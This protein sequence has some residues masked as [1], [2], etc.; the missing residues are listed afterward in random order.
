MKTDKYDLII[1][2]GGMVGA[3]LACMLV[4]YGFR[5][6]LVEAAVY[7]STNQPSFD[8]RALALTYSSGVIFQNLNVWQGLNTNEATAIRQIEVSDAAAGGYVRLAAKDVGQEALGWNVEARAIGAQ[9][10]RVLE[11]N[12]CVSI[13]S[14]MILRQVEINDACVSAI[15]DDSEEGNGHPLSAKLLIIADGSNSALREQLKFI[16]R[17]IPYRQRALVCRVE[18]DRKNRGCAYEH[19]TRSGPL[20]LLPFCENGYS[21]VWTQE[22]EDLKEVLKLSRSEFLVKLQSVFGP[23]AGQFKQLIGERK[24]YPLTLS[25]LKNFA[26]PRVAVV[27]NASHTVHPVAGQGFNLGL[28]DV[29][30]LAQVLRDSHN[31]GWDIGNIE[32]L[33]KFERWRSQEGE[34]VTWFTDGLIQVF[35]N[36]IPVLTPARNFGLDLLQLLPP[37]KRWLLERTM[38]MHGRQPDLA[39]NERK[40]SGRFR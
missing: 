2:G 15:A 40:D 18:T 31:R 9:L 28:R 4:G 26:K 38:G 13:L 36:E 14:P 17:S 16:P 37:V 19:F 35:A 7:S 21:V 29:A 20:A 33:S 23:R 11:S 12:E 27:G 34:Y 1:S 10:L 30:A 22:P 32:V 8:N 24:V 6:A 39:T 25:Y 5:V 3:S